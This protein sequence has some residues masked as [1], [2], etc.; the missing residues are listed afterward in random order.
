MEQ[1]VFKA[2]GDGIET[3]LGSFSGA[4]YFLQGFMFDFKYTA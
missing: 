4:S 1:V 3:S 2:I